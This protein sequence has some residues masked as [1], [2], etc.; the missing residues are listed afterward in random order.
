MVRKQRI[1]LRAA[2]IPR[3]NAMLETRTSEP[4]APAGDVPAQGR[5][6]L[7]AWNRRIGWLSLGLGAATGLILGL[8]SFDGP[9]PVPGW[10]GDYDHTARRLARLG[11]IAFFGLGI[12]NL[13]VSGE[14]RRT[15]LGPLGRKTASWAMNFGN[16]FL[17]LTLF[18]AAAYRPFKYTMSAPALAVFLALVVT[19]YGVWCGRVSSAED[20]PSH[21]KTP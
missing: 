15:V 12:L 19:A 6:P 5:L 11:H 7:W 17:P 9:F 2:R 10:L 8:W 4:T 3:A 14:L 21:E 1:A 18:A 20:W 13:L 16:I